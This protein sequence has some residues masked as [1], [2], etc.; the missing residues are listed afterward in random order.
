ME[1]KPLIDYIHK[2]PNGI[3]L[4]PDYRAM[5]ILQALLIGDYKTLAAYSLADG[6]TIED[7]CF[8]CKSVDEQIY[9][10][11]IP[12][13][14]TNDHE[15]AMGFCKSCY[16]QLKDCNVDLDYSETVVCDRCDS[17]YQLSRELANEFNEDMEAFRESNGYYYSLLC[18]NCY[19]ILYPLEMEKVSMKRCTEKACKCKHI[20]QI[21]LLLYPPVCFCKRAVIINSY[22][23]IV[24]DMTIGWVKAKV[25]RG[26]DL[27]FEVENSTYDECFYEA[28]TKYSELIQTLKYESESDT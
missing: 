1:L 2:H 12:I 22:D 16:I 27:L 17:E 8:L 7:T 23:Y 19:N 21:N 13:S 4:S 26:L 10:V 18:I 28:F 3:Q 20:S 15:S 25:M 9:Y 11:N 6:Y 5:T 14:E 24:F